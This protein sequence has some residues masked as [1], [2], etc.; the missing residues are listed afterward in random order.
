[1]AAALRAFEEDLRSSITTALI[2]LREDSKASLQPSL[3]VN[4][5]REGEKTLV[6]VLEELE[7]CSEFFFSVAFV[8]ESGLILLADA[9]EEAARR[10]VKGKILT[11]TYLNFNN[12]RAFRR[13]LA[14]PNVEARVF[15]GEL[16]AKGYLFK[17]QDSYHLIVGS[18]N[19]TDNALT[20]NQELNLSIT[21][22]QNGKLV[23]DTQR[24]FN[25]LWSH[26]CS[27][28]LT[29]EWI[30][31]YEP[32]YL[33]QQRQRVQV[34]ADTAGERLI[35]PNAMQLAALEGLQTVRGAGHKRALLISATGTGKTYLSAFDV[36][37]VKPARVLFIVH[38][39]RIAGDALESFKNVLGKEYTYG[40]YSSDQKDAAA[41]CLF[42]TVQ[43]LS[44][45]ENLHSFARDAFDYIIV[46]EVHRAGAETYQRVIDYF[47]PKFLLGMSAT[48]ERSDDFDIYAL[49]NHVIA[50]EIRLNEALEND[51]LAPFHYF[52]VHEI[53]M[54]GQLLDE[55]ADF[56]HLVSDERVRHILNATERYGFSGERVRGLMFVSRKREAEELSA[57]LNAGG[58]RTVALSGDDGDERRS[59][60]IDR[61]EREEND[62]FAL[63]YIITVD[64]FNEGVDIPSVNQVVMLRPTQSAIV[65]VQQ[66]GRG[67][68][69]FPGKDYVVVIDFIGN[70]N[71]NYMI[72]M[73]LFGDRSGSK[74]RLR[75]HV[76]S[77]FS[78]LPGA[79]TVSF[80]R[81]SRERVLANINKTNLSK[82]GIIKDAYREL[83]QKVGRIPSLQDFRRFGSIDPQLI[84]SNVGLGTYHRFLSKYEREYA[85]GLSIEQER[86]L[87]FVSK[88]LSE[89][90]R[91]AE[92]VVL[93]RLM[94]G[95]GVEQSELLD[96]IAAMMPDAGDAEVR[97][98]LG[99]AL[100]VLSLEWFGQSAR[101][102]YQPLCAVSGGCVLRST[103]LEAAFAS[104]AFCMHLA[105][106][107][108]YSLGNWVA[109]FRD[110][111]QGAP[112]ALYQRYSRKDACRLLCWEH[113]DSSTVYGYTFKT[114]DWV[115]FVTLDKAE[116]IASSTKYLDGFE[117]PD[118]FNWMTRN[119]VRLDSNEP[120][121]LRE[122]ME[123]RRADNV[124]LFVKKE[125]GEGADHYYLGRVFPQEME[126]ASI[127]DD[128]GVQRPV[129]EVR[130][131]LEREVRHDVYRY[132][133]SF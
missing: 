97:R 58:L 65:F 105:D 22:M 88:E 114:N 66:L 101:S 117:S 119:N 7:T 127:A 124:H 133:T 130:F 40:I 90:K 74:E 76:A 30:A 131:K 113:D 48:P 110:E 82:V 15:N 55:D 116:E 111:C 112:L 53:E 18:S 84:F 62:A 72:P 38:R 11:G 85:C 35:Q 94:G 34:L 14:L 106:L 120:R 92:L 32:L 60:C 125:D 115:I 1:M 61:L 56:R 118:S 51:M 57:K 28:P 20:R 132:L 86:I 104:T 39:R 6:H 107:L 70:Y 123:G 73:A 41:T 102:K 103:Q 93:R 63:D 52:G 129:V 17:H 13:L 64:I 5:Y 95:D 96:E 81:I 37:A 27:S 69:T 45:E 99:S 16:H 31:E 108:E 10:G 29:E 54:D 100:Q 33:A 79:S 126:Q 12:P 24:E 2:D 71:N 78:E 80:D 43:T 47:Q 25:R 59:A 44:R 122:L 19:L 49:F 46:D 83:K 26:E 109:G 98:Q 42:C 87:E 67:L 50:Y 3:I 21:S 121:M 75:K 23:H 128:S 89:G 36:R 8:A 68:R 91:P 9:I 4:N 77:G